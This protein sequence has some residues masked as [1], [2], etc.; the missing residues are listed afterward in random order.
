[1]IKQTAIEILNKLLES[2]HMCEGGDCLNCWLKS[3][4]VEEALSELRSLI[5]KKRVLK[6][7]IIVDGFNIAIDETHKKFGDKL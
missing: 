1:M 2:C 5:P 3:I 6:G 4:S 7:S